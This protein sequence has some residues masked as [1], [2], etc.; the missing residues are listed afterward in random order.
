M[1]FV[2]DFRSFREGSRRRYNKRYLT[3]ADNQNK[4]ET[5]IFIKLYGCLSKGS[6]AKKNDGQK[7]DPFIQKRITFSTVHHQKTPFCHS[8]TSNFDSCKKK[9]ETLIQ[10]CF[11]PLL[12]PC[13]FERRDSVQ[14]PGNFVLFK[15]FR[16]NGQPDHRH[17]VVPR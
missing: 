5:E 17:K 12:L 4:K 7:N 2:A 13:Q 3:T 14:V 11:Q 15:V 16:K 9:L 8:Q 10:Q 1:H 6:L